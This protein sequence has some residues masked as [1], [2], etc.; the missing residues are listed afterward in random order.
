MKVDRIRH[1][2]C[3]KCVKLIVKYFILPDDLFLGVVLDLDTY[4]FLWQVD[5]E[6]YC[7]CV[8]MV[9]FTHITLQII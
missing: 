4:I 5:I 2:S 3:I 9:S 1:A 7:I 6:S 8:N